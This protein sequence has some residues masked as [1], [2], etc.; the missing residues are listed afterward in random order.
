[1]KALAEFGLDEGGE[2]AKAGKKIIDKQGGKEEAARKKL[3][4]ALRKAN[5]DDVFQALK[6][7]RYWFYVVHGSLYFRCI[8]L[9]YDSFSTFLNRMHGEFC[10]IV[11]LWSKKRN[12][13]LYKL[14]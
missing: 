6:V 2:V 1:M 3:E 7:K 11:I 14:H 13:S 10:P 4:E 9:L 8:F 5:F 12:N